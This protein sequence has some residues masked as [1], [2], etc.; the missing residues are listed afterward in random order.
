MA[1]A[2]KQVIKLKGETSTGKDP[3]AEEKAR[4]AVITLDDFMTDHY[5]PFVMPRKRSWRRDEELYR[6]R[7][8]D[9]FGHLRLNQL[10]RKALQTFHA[11]LLKKNLSPASCD[12]HIKLLR[13]ALNMAVEWEMLAV[14]PV[15]GIKLFNA[16][17][18]VEHYLNDEQLE[19]LLH[20]LRT[21]ANRTVCFICMWLLST[22]A[23]L[24][25]ALQATHSQ[26]DA[27]N[28]IWRIPAANSK[29]GRGRVVPLNDSALYVLAQL[30][31]EHSHLFINKKTKLPYTTIMKV[32]DRLRTT[33]GVPHIRIHDLRHGYASLLING[34]RSIYEVSQILGH[35]DV[36]VTQRYAHLSNK[37][38][39]EAANTASV[40]V[41]PVKAVEAA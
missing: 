16:D 15:K 18:K 24:N 22:G 32:W 31:N 28:R 8:K 30:G 14:N 26:I 10:D 34:G 38:L 9:P 41:K 23:R 11:S 25:E 27:T 36:K 5:L 2:R 20:V 33:A 6:I 39:Q 19:R 13:Y 29:S 35:A 17:N 21:D 12:H 3:Q 4:K 37:T 40:L 1:E 7:I